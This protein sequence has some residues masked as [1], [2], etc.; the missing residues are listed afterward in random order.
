VTSSLVSAAIL[1]GGQSRRMGEDKAA[2]R[3]GG[4]PLLLRVAHLI[5]EITPELA[6]I[7]PPER[8]LLAPG[9]PTI[10]DRWPNCGPLG[11]IATAL[12]TLPG[13]V[14][15]VVGCDM[16]FLNPALLRSLIALVPG[17]D[18]VVVRLDGR[19]HPLHAVYRHTA[20]PI[21]EQQLASG[22]LRVRKLLRR[23]QVRYVEGRELEQLDP[24]HLS[25]FNAN[26]PEEWQQALRLLEQGQQPS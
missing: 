9:I 22:D 5:Q 4:E 24:A 18:A 19:E 12:H 20:L 8:A 6:I 25:V 21:L 2:L 7:G 17:Y 26:T 13:E 1:A 23:M 11:G 10:P 16:P 3:I 15:L 14:L